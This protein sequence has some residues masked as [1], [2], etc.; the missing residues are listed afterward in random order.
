M[1]LIKLRGIDGKLIFM[2]PEEN[3][4]NEHQ[5]NL[6]GGL[7]FEASDEIEETTVDE[8]AEKLERNLERARPVR[9]ARPDRSRKRT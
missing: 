2:T 5:K 9:T 1:K 6:L 4:K 3:L 8:K 7:T